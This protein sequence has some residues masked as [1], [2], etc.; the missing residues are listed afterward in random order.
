MRRLFL[1]LALTVAL[2]AAFTSS[3]SAASAWGSNGCGT[4]EQRPTAIVFSCGDGSVIFETEAWS[5]WGFDEAVASG[6]LKHPDVGDPSCARRPISACPIAES[7][8]TVRLWQSSFCPS[9]SRWQFLRLRLE[10][11]DDVDPELR[12]ISERFKCGEYAKF[13]PTPQPANRYRSCGSSRGSFYIGPGLP[14]LRA[15]VRRIITRNVACGPAKRFAHR[16]FFGQECVLCDAPNSYDPGDRVRFRG[17]KCRVTR[18]EPQ[19][20]HCRRGDKRINF[21]T[22]LLPSE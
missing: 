12:V 14:L 9:N 7:A 20:F 10:A 3:A 22:R 1:A 4:S 11:P 6:Y 15:E 8:A 17:F 18:G 2:A 16:L 13:Q 21:K 5:T 19:T